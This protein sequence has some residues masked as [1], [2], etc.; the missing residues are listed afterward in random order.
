M[1]FSFFAKGQDNLEKRFAEAISSMRYNNIYNKIIW[2]HQPTNKYM[3]D[4][5]KG[6]IH[7]TTDNPSISA[8]AQI[9]VLG[10]FN[11]DDKTF[12]WS[13]RN[14]SIDKTLSDKVGQLRSGLPQRYQGNKFT[15]NI[16]FNQKLLALFSH[17]LNANGFDIV[18]QK[19]TIVYFALM[20]IDVLEKDKIK[21]TINLEP[22]INI[23]RND[24]LI[25]T[26]KQFHQEKV[27]V[28]DKHFNKKKLTSDEA[29]DAI[30]KVHLKYW[31]NEDEYF[32][33]AL[34][35]PCDFDEKSTSDWQVLQLKGS[36]RTFVLY[37]SNSRLSIE[38]YAYEI[39]PN[40]KGDKVI[41]GNF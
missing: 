4:Q 35:S 14:A 12:L 18:R 13:D 30:Y 38:H 40:A 28:N 25:K 29:F 21:S 26:I 31:L 19:N 23:V 2:D 27:E 8:V 33:P 11:L 16:E 20:K 10:T 17:Q 5:T 7:Y 6:T 3:V 36:N 15:S 41:I 37:S 39:D 32:F 34:C 24:D 22:H 9:E 1:L